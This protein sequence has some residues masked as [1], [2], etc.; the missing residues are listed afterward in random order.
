MYRTRW[1]AALAVMF[2]ACLAPVRADNDLD[3][4]AINRAH[5]F[6]AKE[7]RGR[8]ILSY[9]HFGAKYEGHKYKETR[10]VTNKDGNRIKGH[11]ALVYTYSWEN[12]GETLVA[13]LCDAKGNVYEVQINGTNAILS[14]PFVLAQ[15]TVQLLGNLLVEAFKDQMTAAERQKVQK[16]VDDADVKALLEWSLVFQQALER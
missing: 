12:N 7:R 1:L 3:Q 6:L 13:F 2:V 8:D 10:F 5:K 14:Q 16:C 9:V 15:A 4:S 11:F